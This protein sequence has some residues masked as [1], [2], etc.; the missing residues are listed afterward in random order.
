MEYFYGAAQ[1]GFEALTG[2]SYD[3]LTCKN[4]HIDPS[5]DECSQCHVDG[6]AMDDVPDEQCYNCHGRQKAEAIGHGI[7]DVHRDAGMRCADC[8]DGN[9]VHG[10]GK[11]YDSMLEA[12]AITAKCENCHSPDDLQDKNDF[13]LRHLG[14]NAQFASIECS[15]CHMQ[16]VV[17]CYNCHFDSEVQGIGKIAYGQF[18]NWKFLVKKKDTGY[19]APANFMTL[20]YFNPNDEEYKAHVVFAPFYAHTIDRNA[21]GRCGDCHDNPAVAEY[22]STGHIEVVTWDDENDMFVQREGIIPVPADWDTALVFDF[23][24]ITVQDPREWDKIEPVETQHQMLFAD[25]LDEM[26]D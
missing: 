6:K 3:E 17:N 4:C 9:D 22:K 16:S 13:H 11:T 24:T 14:E 10:D 25:P 15:A 8:H 19:I 21:T 23:A 12:G 2:V 1:G 18:K 26:P 7:S 5:A 20:S